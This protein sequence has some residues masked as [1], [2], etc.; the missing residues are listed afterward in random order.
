MDKF[1]KTALI[2]ICFGLILG[3]CNKDD[4]VTET[5]EPAVPATSAQFYK[6]SFSLVVGGREK[7]MLVTE[8]ENSEV[9]GAQ[10]SSSNTTVAKVDS[11]GIVT[12]VATGNATISVTASNVISG[13]CDV[14]VIQSPISGLEMPQTQFPIAKGALLFILGTGFSDNSKIILRYHS[15]FK[16]TNGGDEDI[17]VQI[18]DRALNYLS[19]YV[20]ENTG[21]YNI[22][23][24]ENGKQYNLGNIEI[25]TPKLPAYSYDKNKIFWDDT[26]WRRFQLR[27]KVKQMATTESYYP[28]WSTSA[29]YSFN[30]KGY[31]KSFSKAGG[32]DTYYEYDDQNRVIT[33]SER[34]NHYIYK[35]TYGDHNQYLPLDIDLVAT[36]E[37]FYYALYYYGGGVEY[38]ERF[39]L[40]M[41]QKGLTGITYE[42]DRSSGLKIRTCTFDVDSKKATLLLTDLYTDGSDVV[43]TWNFKNQ[44]PYEEIYELN[45]SDTL[46]ITKSIAYQSNGMPSS[47]ETKF[48]SSDSFSSNYEK[49]CPFNL[50]SNAILPGSGYS[51]FEYDANWDLRKHTKDYRTAEF[52]YTSYDEEGN[53]IECYVE[54]KSS[55]NSYVSHLTRTITYW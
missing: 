1:L 33:K 41:Y 9:T 22:V 47:T 50:I 42:E 30:E 26:H 55:G 17:L 2:A 44:F 51:G 34:N 49:N 25:K 24:D 38:Q 53:W 10:W 29:T 54:M 45:G 35:F 11:L 12:A 52:Y 4:T 16:S 3:S 19:F 32:S 15:N 14:T 43:Y 6:T 20:K 40:E 46:T 5:N 8:P 21:S 37:P 7:V 36:F 28:Y 31:L 23:L 27:G 39:D 13:E 18:H 48:N